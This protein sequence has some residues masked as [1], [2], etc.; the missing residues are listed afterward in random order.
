MPNLEIRAVIESDQY[1]RS[2][3]IQSAT[4]ELRRIYRPRKKNIASQQSTSRAVVAIEGD[5]V[6]GTA[7]YIQRCNQIYV[8]G[9]AVHSEYRKNGVCRSLISAIEN[10][11]R[12]AQLQSLALCTIE[13]TGNVKIFEKLGFEATNR[14]TSKDYVCPKGNTV[15]EVEMEC[16]I[17]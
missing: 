15:V 9:I 4:E 11:A 17:T 6:L 13:D 5:R 16:K 12:K 10:I 14:K 8:Q 7:E 3:I 2:E 1:A